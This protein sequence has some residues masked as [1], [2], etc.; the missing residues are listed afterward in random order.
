MLYYNLSILWIYS[1]IN[2]QNKIS[3]KGSQMHNLKLSFPKCAKESVFY[4][5][6]EKWYINMIKIIIIIIWSIFLPWNGIAP[7]LRSHIVLGPYNKL[8][9]RL[10]IFAS[11]H[12]RTCWLR[13]RSSRKH[14]T[15][16]F[17]TRKLIEVHEIFYDQCKA[18]IIGFTQVI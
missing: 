10:S 16:G 3:L 4:P 17:I 12:R 8:L 18:M 9:P 14:R 7:A 6:N 2:F 13:Y 1:M 5:Q 15:S 11:A